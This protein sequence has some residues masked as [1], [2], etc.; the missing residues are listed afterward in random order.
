MAHNRAK[1]IYKDKF[2][3]AEIK[4][5]IRDAVLLCVLNS[6]ILLALMYYGESNIIKIERENLEETLSATLQIERDLIGDEFDYVVSD[7]TFL[8]SNYQDQLS[9][10]EGIE[11]VTKEWI[12][13]SDKKKVYDQIRFL[14]VTGKE[15]I[16]INYGIEGA[17]RVATSMLQNKADRYYFYESIVLN[18][19]Q[20]YISRLDLNM[21]YGIIEYPY[22]PVIRLC[23][24]AYDEN[25]VL[26]GI[27]VLNFKAESLLSDFRNAQDAGSYVHYLINANGYFLSS[28]DPKQ[29]WGFMYES[30]KDISFK[31]AYPEEW[32]MMQSNIEDT[33]LTTCNLFYTDN[34][35]FTHAY[36][37]FDEKLSSNRALIQENRFVLEE[38]AW[39]IVIHESPEGANGLVVAGTAWDIAEYVM[40]KYLMLFIIMDVASILITLL[41]LFMKRARRELEFFSQYDPMTK[42]FNRRAGMQ[43]IRDLMDPRERRCNQ[44]TLMFVDIN[45][46][47]SVND[48]LGHDFGDEL[49]TTVADTLKDSIRNEDF[50]IRMGGDEFLICLS[51]TD[52]EQAENAWHRIVQK[53]DEENK[54][55]LRPYQISVSH[56]IASMDKNGETPLDELIAR[57]D[58]AM[59]AEK[60]EVKKGLQIIRLKKP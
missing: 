50:V 57:A 54:S 8:K 24:P 51:N 53:F 49:I 19:G 33:D 41:L 10:P 6:F 42:T 5:F 2:S 44:I 37:A 47:K 26:L 9:T 11:A 28:P 16:R 14:D 3:K 15:I 29:E 43:K 45:D 40:R 31:N 58:E 32:A 17:Y 1:A 21:E 23:T 18:P 4:Q 20:I 56:G 22:K 34:G 12:T 48:T 60:R 30:K 7:L 52:A 39:T 38:G 46:L 35:L 27:I 36:I 25:D 55:E 13:F 59:Y